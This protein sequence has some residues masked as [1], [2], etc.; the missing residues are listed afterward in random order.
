MIEAAA[1]LREATWGLPLVLLLAGAGLYLTVLLRGLQF[2]ALPA[3]LRLTFVERDEP[4]AEG[5]ISHFQ[6]LMTAIAGGAGAGSVVGVSVALATGGPGAL[7]WMWVAGLLAMA[8]RFAEAV[9]AVRYRETDARGVKSGGPMY[10][11]ENGIRWGGI[12]RGLG[13]VFGVLAVL[14]ALGFGNGVQ[15]NAVATAVSDVSG[16]PA[17]LVGSITALLVGAVVLGGIRSIGRAAGLVVPGLL[18]T[19]VAA[20]VWVLWLNAAALPA[21]FA[22]AFDGMFGGHALGG[23]VAG[24]TLGQVVG[25]GLARGAFSSEAGVGSGAI[26]AAAA[27]TREPVRQALVAMTAPLIDTLVVGTL[28]GLV[29]LTAAP[30]RPGAQ[31]PD[32]VLMQQA[33]AAALPGDVAGWFVALVLAAFALVTLIA[34]AYFGERSAQYVAGERAVLPFRL[35]FIGIIPLGSVLPLESLWA[36]SNALRGVMAVPNLI[37]LVLLSGVVVR[38]T[39]AWFG[40]GER[41]ERVDEPA[42]AFGRS[43]D[44]PSNRR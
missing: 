21:A 43:A 13:L 34:W 33:F 19:Y 26:A 39:K 37:G 44:Q 24:Y 11:L 8:T 1:R 16:A 36:V 4:D 31:P 17:L 18:L 27:R 15:A 40:R 20:A 6:A 10:Y 30:H 22:A 12:G 28:T 14:A 42:E 38:E 5:D 9:L 3:A 35:L 41:G 2:R 23:G 25:S 32:A 7:V 29:L